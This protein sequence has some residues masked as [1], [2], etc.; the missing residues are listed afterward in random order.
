MLDT[1]NNII[2]VNYLLLADTY[3]KADVA[4]Y[5]CY[6]LI[7]QIVQRENIWR[8]LRVGKTKIYFCSD[9]LQKEASVISIQTMPFQ[10][11]Y[12]SSTIGSLTSLPSKNFFRSFDTNS[13]DRHRQHSE[14]AH[15]KQKVAQLKRHQFLSFDI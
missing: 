7:E 4:K 12:L 13:L 1:N 3:V 15:G 10:L 11:R 6:F 5:T 8:T 2:T 9:Y 14:P